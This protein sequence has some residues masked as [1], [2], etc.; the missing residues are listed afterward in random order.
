MEESYYLLSIIKMKYNKTYCLQNIM[1]HVLNWHLL[2]LQCEPIQSTIRLYCALYYLQN[3]I[4]E[5]W[6]II[7]NS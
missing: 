7:F 4:C 2:T 3:S 5:C 1:K 6:E